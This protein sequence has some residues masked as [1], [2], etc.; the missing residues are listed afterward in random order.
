MKK[1]LSISLV[2][3]FMVVL[4]S[5]SGVGS[6]KTADEYYNEGI[7]Y[8]KQGR[9]KEAVNSLEKVIELKPDFVAAYINLGSAYRAID[10]F[11][12]AIAACE[13]AIEL[14]PE[15]PDPYLTLGSAYFVL[16]QTQKAIAACEK[17]IELQPDFASAYLGLGHIYLSLAQ[18]QK[19][20]DYFLRAKE[21]FTKQGIQQ[22]AQEAEQML[23][24][25]P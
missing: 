6:K 1:I 24:R 4:S 2:V 16:G 9:N 3:L 8:L 14:R 25:F 15:I 7:E 17:A 19:A 20:K 22:G 5:C 12:K 18:F 21:L 10:E 23:Q 13:K 11:Q